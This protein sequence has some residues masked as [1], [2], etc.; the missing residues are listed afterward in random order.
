M[1]GPLGTFFYLIAWGIYLLALEA[2]LQRGQRSLLFREPGTYL[3]LA[4]FSIP[5]WLAYEALNVRLL[6]WE[7]WS[8]PASAAVRWPG[9][10]LAYATVLPAIL[11]TAEFLRPRLPDNLSITPRLGLSD[12]RWTTEYT[13]LGM[14][15][16]A[17]PLL[18]PRWFF[19]LIWAPAFLLCEPWL[20]RR[21]P[22]RSWLKAL[23]AGRP[24]DF[25][26]LLLSGLVCGLL[27]ES[28]N[29]WAGAKWKYTVPWPRGP[30]LFE[31]P[32]LGY[33]GF[34][35]F[36][37]SCASLWRSFDELWRSAGAPRRTAAVLAFAAFSLAAFQA[38]DSYT[39]RSFVS[40][41]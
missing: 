36:A 3:R 7:Y 1:S 33:L 17:L 16:L 28:L 14:L 27:W 21:V 20:A 19:P 24:H 23:A 30:K 29:F 35:P 26:A 6:N 18:W 22:R 40:L 32:L 31:M 12:K 38:I 39:V 15:C 5:V 9:Y 2:V 4:L 41:W 13:I 10:A 25:Y 11:E 37:L 8:L 34:P